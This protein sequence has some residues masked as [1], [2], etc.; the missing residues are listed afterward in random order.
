MFSK[1]I[2][3]QRLLALRRGR[4][5]SQEVLAEFLHVTK[6]QISD[7]ENGKKTTTL[8]KFAMICEHYNVSADYLLGLTEE[9]RAL[10]GEET[11]A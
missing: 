2:F 10:D 5:E 11:E 9:K 8:E 1:E 7:M 3:G 6:T 4:R